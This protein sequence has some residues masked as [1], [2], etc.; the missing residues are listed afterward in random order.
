[1][2]RIARMVIPGLPYHITQ[3]GNRGEAVFFSDNDRRRY[4]SWLRDYSE[5]YG[6]DVM[7][8]C[9]MTNHVHLVGEPQSPDSLALTLRSLNMRHSQAI[10]TERGWSGHL[11]QGRFF[12]TALDDPHLWAAVRYVERNPVRA[13]MV[14]RAEEHPWSSAAFHLGLRAD[15]II[16]TDTQWGAEI[17]EWS[18]F[19]GESEDAEVIRTL[20]DRTRLGFPCGDE[21]FVERV[22]KMLGRTLVLRGRGRPRKG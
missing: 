5:R 16:R 21:D 19:L 12:S 17:D 13:G 15:R 3:R 14:D 11:W 18:A 6:L 22:S 1:M 9:L 4:L 7:G 20:R 2:P 10:N 8:Y